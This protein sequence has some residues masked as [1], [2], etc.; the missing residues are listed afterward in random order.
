M[1]IRLMDIEQDYPVVKGWW[2]L[3]GLNAPLKEILPRFAIMAIHEDGDPLAATF[4]YREYCGVVAFVE[5]TTTDPALT[6]LLA[7]KAVRMMLQFIV[8]EANRQGYPI[9]LSSVESGSGLQ[10]VMNR[11]GWINLQGTPHDCMM[12]GIENSDN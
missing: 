6:P 3:R 12:A 10:G 11:L 5:W 1:K 4:L 8:P 9:V 2:E 7:E